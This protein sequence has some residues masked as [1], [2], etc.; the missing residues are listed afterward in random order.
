MSLGFL[1]LMKRIAASLAAV[2]LVLVTSVLAACG[3]DGAEPDAPVDGA[4]A[5][6]VLDFQPNAVHAGIYAALADGSLADRGVD[7]TVQIPGASTDAPKLLEAGRADLAV[8]DI[9]DLAIARERGADLVG[10]G[11]LVQRPLAAVI[12]GDEAKVRTPADLGGAT[13]GVTGLPSDDAVLQAVVD[14]AGGGGRDGPE[15]VNIGFDS[16]A[17]LSAGR[18][19]AATAFWNVEGVALREQGVPTREFRVD[20]YGAP[21]F[22]E[23]VLVTSREELDENR[24]LL[25]SIVDGLRDGYQTVIDDPAAAL[26]AETAAVPELDRETLDAQMDALEGAFAP[27]LLLDRPTLEEWADY[28]VDYGIV[29]AR[30][31]LDEVFDFGLSGSGG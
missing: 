30:P 19:D 5:T 14:S 3:G 17:A 20:N 16:V 8:M 22:P 11:G 4:A 28:V 18:V 15:T 13:V 26:D 12:A 27:T 7:L 25:A 31:D 24:D 2:L 23:L 29:D 21:R 9:Q 10:I 6:L 1:Q